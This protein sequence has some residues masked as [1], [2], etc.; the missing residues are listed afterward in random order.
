MR[1]L[2]K[3]QIKYAALDGFKFLEV[4]LYFGGLPDLT[5]GLELQ[6]SNDGVYL[7]V[8]PRNALAEVVATRGTI[9]DIKSSNINK[10]TC[11]DGIVTQPY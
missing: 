5:K 3:D 11:P 7:D 2:S 9:G 4:S 8:A 6:E 10:W 1:D